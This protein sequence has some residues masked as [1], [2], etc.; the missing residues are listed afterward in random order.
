MKKRRSD[1]FNDK[2]DVDQRGADSDGD[3]DGDDIDEDGKEDRR[4]LTEYGG[5]VAFLQ[6]L[7]P[8]ELSQ[9]V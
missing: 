5:F 7:N 9:S 6:N 8:H 3:D 4:L 2:D 1:D